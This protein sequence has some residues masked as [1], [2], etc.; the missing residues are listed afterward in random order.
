MLLGRRLSPFRLVIYGI[1]AFI[2]ITFF[3]SLSPVPL[4]APATEAITNIQTKAKEKLGPHLPSW[5]ESGVHKTPQPTNGTASTSSWYEHWTWLN[6]FGNSK[7]FSDSRTVL[8][9]LPK[10]CCIYAYYDKDVKKEGQGKVDDAVMLAWRRAWWAAGF[11]PVILSPLDARKHGLYKKVKGRLGDKKEKLEYNILRWL[12]WDRMGTGVLSDFRIFPMGIAG[13]PVIPFLRRCDYGQSVTRFTGLGSALFAAD[14]TLIKAVVNNITSID[15]STVPEDIT[16]PADLAADFFTADPKPTS[17]AYYSRKVV[18]DKYATLEPHQLPKLINAHLHTHF[19]SQYPGGVQ[20]LNPIKALSDVFSLN[21][22][23]LAQKLLQ[24]PESPIR[25][26]F[27]PQKTEE[28]PLCGNENIRITTQ[29][30]DTAAFTIAGIPHPMTFQG[31]MNNRLIPELDWVRRNSSRDIFVKAVTEGIAQ[32]GTGSA[33]RAVKLKELIAASLTSSPQSSDGKGSG[34]AV[35][36]WGPLERTWDL[37]ELEWTL[38]FTFSDILP[39]APHFDQDED[40]VRK[41]KQI[42]EDSKRAIK[43][44]STGLKTLRG[45]I[46]GWSLADFEVWKFVD[47]FEER[48][49]SEREAWVKREKGFGKGLER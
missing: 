9:P 27:A 35:S 28:R 36:I 1:I 6:P 47:A 16:S 39:A 34:V 13:D 21:S 29:Y 38:G 5:Y 4:P 24:C 33:H 46:E 20:V 44:T 11:E 31:L 12:A 49:R 40:M 22:Y 17:I 10:R 15:L 43:A 41:H 8:P 19:L 18:N 30:V 3:T 32:K 48:R 45:A 25:D 37:K 2:T 14:S 26:T 7:D 42:I 23:K